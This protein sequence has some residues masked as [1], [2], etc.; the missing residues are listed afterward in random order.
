MLIFGAGV[1]GEATLHACRAK[2]IAVEAFV[3]HRLRGELLG[4]PILPGLVEGQYYLTSPN[5]QDM[6]VPIERIGAQDCY[7]ESGTPREVQEGFGVTAEFI[8]LAALRVHARKSGR[9]VSAIP[10]HIAA[11]EK[12]RAFMQKKI[13]DAAIKRAP[14]KW[15]K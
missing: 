15:K 12:R 5:A 4:V 3:D 11:S 2:G 1:L 10:E 13:M 8:A 14:K 9:S 7:G 6:I